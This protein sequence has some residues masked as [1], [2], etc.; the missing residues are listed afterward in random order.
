MLGDIQ[1]YCV[2]KSTNTVKGYAGDPKEL[3]D[4]FILRIVDVAVDN[5][6]FLVLNEQGTA[7]AMVDMPDVQM[8]FLCSKLDGVIIPPNLSLID[9]MK[10]VHKRLMIKG[11]YTDIVR[12]T[13]IAT[14]LK[15]NKFNDDFLFTNQ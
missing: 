7:L 8:H 6:G 13:V 1:G 10:E 12:C 4:A 9:Q 2:L 5:S 14:S 15:Q 3:L 11:G